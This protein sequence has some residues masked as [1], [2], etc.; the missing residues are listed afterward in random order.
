MG[1]GKKPPGNPPSIQISLVS[2][3]F[4]RVKECDSLGGKGAAIARGAA[5]ARTKAKIADF[6][7][8]VVY[9]R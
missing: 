6:I 9:E 7:L 2:H 5:A 3:V 1:G 4:G 8:M